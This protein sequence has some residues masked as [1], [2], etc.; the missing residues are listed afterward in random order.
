[1]EK[2]RQ[3][4]KTK[5]EVGTKCCMHDDG[6]SYPVTVVEVINRKK[7]KVRINKVVRTGSECTEYDILDE[8]CKDVDEITFLYDTKAGWYNGRKGCRRILNFGYQEY[9]IDRAS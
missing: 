2:R 1:M 7:I 5:I 8:F 3:T 9:Y 6:S 4:T